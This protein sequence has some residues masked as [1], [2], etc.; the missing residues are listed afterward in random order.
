MAPVSGRVERHEKLV[1]LSGPPGQTTEFLVRLEA[2]WLTGG[3]GVLGT[4]TI[5]IEVEGFGLSPDVEL[6]FPGHLAS[7]SRTVAVRLGPLPGEEIRVRIT[8]ELSLAAGQWVSVAAGASVL[9]EPIGASYVFEG[10]YGCGLP[11]PD[12]I[13]IGVP[14]LGR[15]FGV[16]VTHVVAGTNAPVMF[17]GFSNTRWG[18][19]D[20]PWDAS[21]IG[22]SACL[23][24]TD[25]TFFDA[26]V[27]NGDRARWSF[28]FPTSTALGGLVFFQQA[29]V[30]QPG[31]NA[32]GLVFSNAYRGV[33]GI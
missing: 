17:T 20:L 12:L 21:P 7:A 30:V 33:I 29:V 11:I 16:D 19:I 10:G 23:L 14:G 26:M 8:T 5:R 3:Q 1:I 4:G 27:V 9:A 32:A 2:V 6:A 22:M 31:A 28:A 15:T 18:G 13:P 24:R 25:V